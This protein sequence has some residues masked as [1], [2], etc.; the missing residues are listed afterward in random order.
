MART[1][2]REIL[3]DQ[4]PETGAMRTSLLYV[5]ELAARTERLAAEITAGNLALRGAD[6]RSAE[7][8]GKRME[9]AAA[10]ARSAADALTGAAHE[11]SRVRAQLAAERAQRR[12][13]GRAGS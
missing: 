9:G 13:P 8:V 1:G 7:A 3:A 11:L 10:S 12:R 6:A 4:V 2:V 5:W